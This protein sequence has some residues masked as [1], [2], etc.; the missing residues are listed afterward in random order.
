ML[1]KLAK[2]LV[3]VLFRLFGLP[4]IKIVWIR[5][6]A[7]RYDVGEG[8]KCVSRNNVFRYAYEYATAK[9]SAEEQEEF[10]YR[11]KCCCSNRCL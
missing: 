8:I 2:N 6:A 3:L 5:N 1:K 7:Y 4:D 11:S 10:C 9:L